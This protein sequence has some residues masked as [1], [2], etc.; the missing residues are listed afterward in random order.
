MCLV[1][2]L[3]ERGDRAE[4]E[5][6]GGAGVKSTAE[7]GVRDVSGGWGTWGVDTKMVA[8]S[9]KGNGGWGEINEAV[10]GGQGGLIFGWKW[11]K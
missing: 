9:S 8:F 5:G 7:G 10:L 1:P 3:R 2:Q 4:E 6:Q 11:S